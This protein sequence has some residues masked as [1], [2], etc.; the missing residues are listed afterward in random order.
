MDQADVRLPPWMG[1]LC[2]L[3]ATNDG[4]MLFA[5]HRAN[6]ICPYQGMVL[7]GLFAFLA[8]RGEYYSPWNPQWFNK[9]ITD[10]IP[11]GANVIRPVF[12]YFRPPCLPGMGIEIPRG[13]PV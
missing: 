9:H 12:W 2:R 8:G 5:K 11:V 7:M 13:F 10:V 4:Q 1:N 3:A 6:V